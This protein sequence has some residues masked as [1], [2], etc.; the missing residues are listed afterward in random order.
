MRQQEKSD[1]SNS[2]SNAAKEP[3]SPELSWQPW[4]VP[5]FGDGLVLPLPSGLEICAKLKPQHEEVAAGHLLLPHLRLQAKV[6]NQVLE[7]SKH[8]TKQRQA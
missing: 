3:G 7:A 8:K 2:N 5:L 1:L 6:L 4:Q